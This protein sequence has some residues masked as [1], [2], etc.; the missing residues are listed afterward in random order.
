MNPPRERG[1]RDPVHQVRAR[2]EPTGQPEGIRAEI[3]GPALTG[4]SG[5][6]PVVREDHLDPVDGPLASVA[7]GERTGLAERRCAVRQ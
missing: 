5:G 4:L 2:I 7:G 1:S 3:E 6:V